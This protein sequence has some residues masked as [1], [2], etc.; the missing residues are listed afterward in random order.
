MIF[1]LDWST[2]VLLFGWIPFWWAVAI[3]TLYRMNQ[4]DKRNRQRAQSALNKDT[5]GRR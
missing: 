1:G 3:L 4:N 2:V 5:G